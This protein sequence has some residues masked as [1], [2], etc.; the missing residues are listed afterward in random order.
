M[1]IEFPTLN[2]IKSLAAELKLDNQ[3]RN[4]RDRD[5]ENIFLKGE[6]TG[7]LSQAISSETKQ[8][9]RGKLLVNICRNAIID[10]V[11]ELVMLPDIK[12]D[13]PGGLPHQDSLFWQQMV[14]RTIRHY[15]WEQNWQLPERM[16]DLAFSLGLKGRGVVQAFPNIKE[17]RV[18][19]WFRD[20]S[21]YYAVVSSSGS[22]YHSGQSVGP[23][24]PPSGG[25]KHC[26]VL[27]IYDATGRE[28]LR[29][30]P[31]AA[32]YGIQDNAGTH[33]MIEYWDD[34]VMV[35]CVGTRGV[36]GELTYN[37]ILTDDNEIMGAEHR[38][39]FV[40]T[41]FIQDV[42]IPGRIDATTSV[43]HSI[44]LNENL[45]DL[46]LMNT[47]EHRERL[48]GIWLIK[49]PLD[50]PSPWPESGNA[51]V[52]VGPDGDARYIS[53]M[54]NPSDM[55]SHISGIKEMAYL[56]LRTNS[57]RMGE[58]PSGTLTG[59][60]LNA[61]SS[62]PV[63]GEVLMM[64]ERVANALANIDQKAWAMS[65]K[66]FGSAKQQMTLHSHKGPEALTFK[67]KD[68][69]QH[70]RHILEVFPLAHDVP[71]LAV[72]MMQLEGSKNISK[73]SLLERMPGFDPAEEMRR[74][75][76]ERMEEA[77]EQMELMAAMQPQQPQSP[78]GVEATATGLDRGAIPDQAGRGLVH[79]QVPT[80]IPG[81]VGFLPGDATGGQ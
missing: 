69:P 73:R 81:R 9:K 62:I 52:T 77:K 60:G 27:F 49:N 63:A 61:A 17:K 24:A 20:P 3:E 71:S 44:A 18:D 33:E 65:N 53:K 22:G 23:G 75:K 50:V 26:P 32:A 48:G 70:F 36:T 68:L 12:V 59:R 14:T 80:P 42:H 45:N 47:E 64:R 1:P 58:L 55:G 15:F 11:I 31:T 30:Y 56:G 34:D 76:E 13:A 5:L 21:T 7:K 38:L 2:E 10:R 28:I 39:G 46:L 66:F 19:L 25:Y 37:Y 74:L 72:L 16:P 54:D 78:E 29:D 41:E 57:V 40:P 51:I 67:F 8:S 6:F 79:G 35:R 43:Y 4:E